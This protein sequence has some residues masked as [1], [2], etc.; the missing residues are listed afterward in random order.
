[1]SPY[2]LAALV[3][4]VVV[5]GVAC[6]WFGHKYLSEILDGAARDYR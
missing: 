5:F 4:G 1:M 6:Y 2:W 3:S